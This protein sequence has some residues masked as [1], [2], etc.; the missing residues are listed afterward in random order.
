MRSV[1][2]KVKLR[3]VL[4]C[5]CN[6]AHAHKNALKQT[7]TIAHAL[8][9]TYTRLNKHHFPP[10]FAMCV[11]YM[12]CTIHPGHTCTVLYIQVIHVLYYTS[13]S[14]MY[15]TIHPGHTCT[16]LY[17]QVIHVLYYT[18]RPYMYC[19]IHPAIQLNTKKNLFKQI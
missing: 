19:T 16:V 3:K 15:C 11:S 6:H 1:H 14:Y 8:K 18:S 7:F 9:R 17:I 5:Q 10:V 4:K 13:R 12:Y 2:Q